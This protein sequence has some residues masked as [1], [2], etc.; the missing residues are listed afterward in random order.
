MIHIE[1]TLW[2]IL[3]GATTFVVTVT[4]VVLRIYVAWKER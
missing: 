1:V 2:D 4:Y 3:L